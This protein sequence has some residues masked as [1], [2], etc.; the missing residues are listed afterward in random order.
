MIQRSAL[1]CFCSLELGPATKSTP[2]GVMSDFDPELS[3]IFFTA[4]QDRITSPE[5]N[6]ADLSIVSIVLLYKYT[7]LS[8]QPAQYSLVY[9]TAPMLI[10]WFFHEFITLVQC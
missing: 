3:A 1:K 5:T 8:P 4:I 2:E 7:W 10:E 6:V 9:H